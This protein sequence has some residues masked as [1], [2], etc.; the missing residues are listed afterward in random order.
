MRDLAFSD[1][2]KFYPRDAAH[3]AQPR[4]PL[5]SSALPVAILSPWTSRSVWDRLDPLRGHQHPKMVQRRPNSRLFKRSL[6]R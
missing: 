2:P 6:L 5:P 1:L 3:R 4:S